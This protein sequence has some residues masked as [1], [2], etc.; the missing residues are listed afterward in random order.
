[1]HFYKYGVIVQKVF[2]YKIMNWTLGKKILTSIA[3]VAIIAQSFSPYMAFSQKAY[4]QEVT[5]VVEQSTPASNAAD[6]TVTETPT[7]TVTETPTPTDTVTPTPTE[8]PTPEVTTQPTPTVT[9]DETVTVTPSPTDNL[10]PPPSNNSTSVTPASNSAA[11]YPNQT[12]VLQTTK[13]EVLTLY[14][15]T[16]FTDEKRLIVTAIPQS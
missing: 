1:L 9:P 15:C 14:T 13:K 5:P 11:V 3:L 10:S 16:G 8:A 4:A 2:I 12:E 6:A 7:P